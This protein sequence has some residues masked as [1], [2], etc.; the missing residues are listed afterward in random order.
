MTHDPVN[1]PA[2][3]N[4]GEVEVI[5]VIRA[6][7]GDLGFVAFC[8]GQVVKY[9]MRAGLK[10]SAAEDEGKAAWYGQMAGHVECPQDVPDPRTVRPG[11][12]P[13]PREAIERALNA[14]VARADN[15]QP[16]RVG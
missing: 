3:Y 11:W 7:L 4:T 16:W 15:D 2:H 5:D 6:L 13:A 12:K 8:E 9:R 14:F 10:G 1:N